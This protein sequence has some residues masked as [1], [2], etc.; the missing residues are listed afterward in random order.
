[1]AT[2]PIIDKGLVGQMISLLDTLYHWGVRDAHNQNDEGAAMEFLQTHSE[3]GVY[4]FLTDDYN[5]TVEEWQLRLIQ[6]ARLTSMFG[7]MYRYF[8]KMGRFA[9][10]YLSCFLNVAMAWYCKGV[11]DYYAYPNNDIA[12][13]NDAKRVWWTADKGLRKYNN[14]EAVETIQ[15]QCFERE[16]KDIA[17]LEAHA[18]DYKAKRVALKPDH[19]KWFRRS[20]GLALQ[21]RSD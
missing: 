20:V 12:Q 14:R 13:F 9:S 3:V 2:P 8:Q 4:G 6:Q 18:D 5:M 21:K 10:N 7:C 16:R 15:L 19:Y 1:M 17:Y 11:E